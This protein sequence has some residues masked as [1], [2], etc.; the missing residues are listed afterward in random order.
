MSHEFPGFSLFRSDRTG[1]QGGGVALYLKEG[2]TGELLSKFDNSVCQLL[3]VKIHQHDHV[4]AVMY[5][6]PD[7]KLAEFAEVLESLDSVLSELPT[8]TPN[9]TVMG[10]MNFP[11]KAVKWVRSQD[12]YLTPIVENHRRGGN[13]EW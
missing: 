11:K 7:T 13:L 1:R 5:R 6:P 9:I 12:G 4:V 3:V 10:D 2:L 8:P